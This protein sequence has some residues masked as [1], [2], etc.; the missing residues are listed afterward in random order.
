[1]T[2]FKAS[3]GSAFWSRIRLHFGDLRVEIDRKKAS[4]GLIVDRI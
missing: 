4:F 2:R 1:M 3:F